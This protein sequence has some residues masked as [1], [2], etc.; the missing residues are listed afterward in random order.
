MDA[1]EALNAFL[2]SDREGHNTNSLNLREAA[3]SSLFSVQSTK[4]DVRGCLLRKKIFSCFSF[5]FICC[6]SFDH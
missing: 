2:E 4:R 6:R 3:K 1:L 5:F